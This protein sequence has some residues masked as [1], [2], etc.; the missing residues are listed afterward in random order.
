[1]RGRRRICLSTLGIAAVVT[2]LVTAQAAAFAGPAAA[3]APTIVD[4]GTLPGDD[5]SE[6]SGLNN[7]GTM[8]GESTIGSLFS[9]TA[10]HAVSWNA[11]GTIT[12]LPLPPGD[13]DPNSDAV[14]INDAG[15]IVGRSSQGY[16]YRTLRWNTDGTVSTLSPLPGDQDSYP[17]AISADGTVIGTSFSATGPTH[18]VRWSPDGTVTNLPNL[19]SDTYTYVWAI[20]STD[21]ITGYSDSST[22]PEHAVRWN[23]DGSITD[24]S[25]VLAGLPVIN[26]AGAIAA[27]NSANH[28]TRLNPDGSTVD[29][30][31]GSVPTAIGANGTMVGGGR[32]AEFPQYTAPI[33]WAPDGTATGLKCLPGGMYSW[34]DSIGWAEEVNSTGT[35]VGYTGRP[36]SNYQQ[37]DHA[38]SWTP[39][40]AVTALGALP[41]ANESDA[42]LINDAGTIVGSSDTAS[43]QSHAVMWRATT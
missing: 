32:D 42:A 25:T 11:A 13:T 41:G 21:T 2:A 35:I 30:G 27:V 20:N 34:P 22:Q 5:N 15:V 10:T 26:A 14:A 17:S 36:I 40:G 9:P 3:S 16:S 37:Q 4:L 33:S 7:A 39:S 18:A 12:A 28:G 23:P 31:M 38:V 43:G 29:L 24:L 6:V 8:V 19:H 1:M